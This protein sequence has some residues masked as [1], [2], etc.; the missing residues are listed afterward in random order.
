MEYGSG[1]TYSS[2]EKVT[3]YAV[4]KANTYIVSYNANGGSGAPSEQTKTYGVNLTLSSTSPT[5]TNYN[6]KGWAKSSGGSV[7]YQPGG[8]Y[9]SNASVTLY[10]VWEIA[11][12][13]PRITGFSAVRCNL[14]GT[15]VNDGTCALVKF[16]WETD[17]N[18][19][20]INV[21]WS[22]NQNSGSVDIEIPIDEETGVPV[23]FGSVD[24]VVGNDEI[25]NDSTYTITV[26]V[27]DSGGTSPASTTLD[28]IDY[29]IDFLSGGNG[30]ALFKPAEKE[31]FEVD[32]ESY[33]NKTVTVNGNLKA[34]GFQSA[35][36][37]QRFGGEWIGFYADHSN[38]KN[39]T[40]RKAWIG[41]DGTTT[42][43]VRNEAGSSVC[44]CANSNGTGAAL[45]TDRFRATYN[46]SYY[47]GDSNYMWKAV[48]AI[49][50]TIQ[51]SDRNQKTDIQ[52]IDKKYLDLFEKL[53]PVTFKLAGAEHD[54]THVGFIAQDVKAAM[55]EL[56]IS[57]EEFAAYCRDKKIETIEVID[58]ET[59]MKSERDIEILDEDG[60]PVYLYSLRYT[61]F[62]ALNTYM[63]QKLFEKIRVL[64]QEIQDLKTLSQFENAEDA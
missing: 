43:Y 58:P 52:E 47:L 1:S 46:D 13:K 49:N 36:G 6:F 31:G 18:A 33:F 20:L 21:A 26:T 57:P 3:L 32:R 53:L 12:L 16:N 11:Y 8:T 2:N 7:A 56:D 38:A 19:T 48:Y 50:G 37:F 17:Y 62:I 29:I 35:V 40:N 4:W 61:E 45:S 28:G 39:G 41:H 54:R 9:S 34:S 24:Q 64:E 22:S 59:G 14:S 27:S 44:L 63:I 23:T 25:L 5:R 15:A 10:A 30:V 55:D 51:T 60:N 42:L